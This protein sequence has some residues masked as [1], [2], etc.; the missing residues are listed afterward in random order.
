MLELQA[1]LR[2]R[3]IFG[4]LVVLTPAPALAQINL[5]GALGQM[6]NGPGQGSSLSQ[7]EIGSGLKDLLKVAA[8]TVMGK[9]ATAISAIPPSRFPCHPRCRKCRSRWRLSAPRG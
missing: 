9:V 8:R 2:R 6:M 3:T 5:P 4:F 1:D 7:G